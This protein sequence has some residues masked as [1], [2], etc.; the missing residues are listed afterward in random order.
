LRKKRVK[1]ITLRI[2]EN[3]FNIVDSFAKSKGLSVSAYINSVIKSQT[4]YFIPLASNERVSIP[5]KALYSLFSFANK[6]S[7]DD[8][9]AQ[10]AIELK[11]TVQLI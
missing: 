11:H 6:D 1:V 5:K 4:E 3:D 2:N 10:W 9:V 8:L 7:L